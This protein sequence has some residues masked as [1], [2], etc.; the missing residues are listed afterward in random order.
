MLAI[1]A[2]G[3]GAQ[4]PG[5]LTPWLELPGV[6][7][8]VNELSDA[9]EID[10]LAAGTR[11]NT[12]EI[13]AT[14]V[15]QPLV[16]AAALVSARLLND[17]GVHPD[18]VAGHSVGEWAA[19]VLSG[20]LTEREA[21]HLVAR[22]GREMAVA[23]AIAPTGMSAVLGGNRAEVLQ[24]FAELGLIAA[25]DNGGGQLVAGGAQAALDE[26]AAN[27]PSGARVR[28]L[29]VAGAFHTPA[30]RAALKPL[31]LVAAAADPGAPTI[32]FLSNLDGALIDSVFT[33]G[34]ITAEGSEVL[35]RLVQQTAAP[36]RWDLCTE[37]LQQLNITALIELAPA[38]ALAG[39]ARRALP[40]ITVIALDG[41]AWIEQLR[42]YDLR[43]DLENRVSA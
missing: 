38:G 33:D 10:L 42:D 32:P 40:G 9:A 11:W 19:A 22:R 12:N 4:R 37:T 1:V 36:V 14:E 30:M 21:M 24:R 26:L 2:P 17:S 25:N 39:L 35:R 28:A 5:F 29:S 7:N 27:P 6:V 43:A 16:V 18:V 8:H 13:R 23:C 41:P 15:A 20:V 3:Q 34:G 31:A